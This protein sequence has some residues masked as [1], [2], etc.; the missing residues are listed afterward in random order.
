MLGR[1]LNLPAQPVGRLPFPVPPRIAFTGLDLLLDI[2]VA[3]TQP[4]T[5][6]DPSNLYAL[7][8][9]GTALVETGRSLALSSAVAELDPHKKMV[10]SDEFGCGVAF[11]AARSMFG[12]AVF[13]DVTTAI[14][15]GWLRPNQGNLRRPDYVALLPSGDMLLFE[16]KGSQSG[17][18][19]CRKQQ[20][21]SGCGQL[22]AVGLGRG[23][24]RKIAHRV[25]VATAIAKDSSVWH[26]QALI[27]DPPGRP[28]IV[29]E[30]SGPPDELIVRSHY[31]RVASLTADEELLDHLFPDR[32]RPE[33]ASGPGASVTPDIV[34]IRGEPF[35]GREL[36]IDSAEGRLRIFVGVHDGIRQLLLSPDRGSAVSLLLDHK[37]KA[38][39]QVSSL[40]PSAK[41]KEWAALSNDGCVLY[42]VDELAEVADRPG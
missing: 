9:Y 38:L 20:I 37:L 27:G 3:C 16:A 26:S 24:T 8:R 25:V 35:R 13:L 23:F 31:T 21:P 12:A 15:R 22:A 41:V 5:L 30:P 28:K 17:P 40:T 6:Y 14:S 7:L 4:H 32:P 42:V 34:E 33:W 1:S 19:Y 29:L 2:G 36:Q 18:T 10:L 11:R 39:P